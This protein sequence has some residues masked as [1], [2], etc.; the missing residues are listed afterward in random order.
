MAMYSE[1]HPVLSPPPIDWEESEFIRIFRVYVV[2][3]VPQFSFTC[4]YLMSEGSQL[5]VIEMSNKN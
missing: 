3:A 5:L 4:F 1:V 2:A